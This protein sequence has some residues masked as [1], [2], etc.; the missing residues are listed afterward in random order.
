MAWNPTIRKQWT[1]LMS[2]I[3]RNEILRSQFSMADGFR[4]CGKEFRMHLHKHVQIVIRIW[5]IGSRTDEWTVNL[6]PEL[7]INV[8]KGFAKNCYPIPYLTSFFKHQWFCCAQCI[9]FIVVMS[10]ISYQFECIC[11]WIRCVVQN[12]CWKVFEHAVNC[13]N[14]WKSNMNGTKCHCVWSL[15]GSDNNVIVSK[16]NIDI[17]IDVMVSSRLNLH[18]KRAT[19]NLWHA[20]TLVCLA[21]HSELWLSFKKWRSIRNFPCSLA[22]FE[23]IFI[24]FLSLVRPKN[25][26]FCD[27][28]SSNAFYIHQ[29]VFH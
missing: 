28:L 4:K 25:A 20:V 18:N 5:I 22:S 29:W 12:V 24:R 16:R 26:F 2:T 15:F 3:I 11:H 1:A 19:S 8:M 13:R 14:Q 6:P 7:R 9:Q 23:F 27:V 10:H 17:I 21:L